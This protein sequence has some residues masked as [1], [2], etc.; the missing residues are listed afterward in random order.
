MITGWS[1]RRGRGLRNGY[2]AGTWRRSRL[3]D[4]SCKT[5][6]CFVT[7]I[8]FQLTQSDLMKAY[9]EARTAK[10]PRLEQGNVERSGYFLLTSAGATGDPCLKRAISRALRAGEVCVALELADR[11]IP[12]RKVQIQGRGNGNFKASGEIVRV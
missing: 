3:V 1:M 9:I 7:Q 4:K 8:I 5:G 2:L 6:H 12:E 10:V 11:F